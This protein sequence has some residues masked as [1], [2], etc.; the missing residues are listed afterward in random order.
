MDK[1]DGEWNASYSED[2]TPDPVLISGLITTAIDKSAQFKMDTKH[3]T[4]FINQYDEGRIS[5]ADWMLK[6]EVI[7]RR[8][9]PGAVNIDMWQEWTNWQEIYHQNNTPYAAYG[10]SLKKA[11][12]NL[13]E[14][15]SPQAQ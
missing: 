8:N 14:G 1:I 9:N 12:E 4:A 5:Y 7:I 3:P 11:T 6:L 13:M 10:I 2:I 15:Q